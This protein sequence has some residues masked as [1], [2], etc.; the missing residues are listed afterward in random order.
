MHPFNSFS[1][2]QFN[3]TNMSSLGS[4]ILFLVRRPKAWP[5]RSPTSWGSPVSSSNHR[6]F[7]S[8]SS[9]GGNEK[10]LSPING[11]DAPFKSDRHHTQSERG[12]S[13]RRIHLHGSQLTFWWFLNSAAEI[14]SD[15]VMQHAVWCSC[16]EDSQ[17][18]VYFQ[19]IVIRSHVY[20]WGWT[21]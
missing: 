11:W 9:L 13:A 18:W 10:R 21:Q 6:R 19:C 2:P 8:D 16:R 20:M 14:S 1:C 15:A 3:Q 17:R 5:H 4:L 12:V 7:G